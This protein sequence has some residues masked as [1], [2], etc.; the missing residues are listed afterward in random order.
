MTSE[1]FIEELLFEAHQKGIFDELMEHV[2]LLKQSKP[3]LNRYEAYE[4]AYNKIL[5][6]KKLAES[7]QL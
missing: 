4:E 1:Q 7:K 5:A 2:K 3:Y 6:E